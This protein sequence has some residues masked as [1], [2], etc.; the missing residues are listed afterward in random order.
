MSFWR[1]IQSGHLMSINSLSWYTPHHQP[2]PISPNANS[3]RFT[4]HLFKSEASWIIKV[5]NL[6][7][8]TNWS[9]PYLVSINTMSEQTP[10]HEPSS[11]FQMPPR[12]IDR[13]SSHISLKLKLLPLLMPLTARLLL[14]LQ[15]REI[16]YGLF[17]F[18]RWNISI[19][20]NYSKYT[21]HTESLNQEDPPILAPNS[22][23]N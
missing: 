20:F 13:W 16:V 11:I 5:F 3:M 8:D 17:A 4:S 10:H 15:W 2:S 22:K 23:D 6:K 9:K 12:C 21:S 14:W 1:L 7:V 18:A 19:R